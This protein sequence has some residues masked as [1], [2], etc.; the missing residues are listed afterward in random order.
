[1]IEIKKKYQ[2]CGCSACV[3][4]C[5]KQCIS[6]EED[7]EGFLYPIVDKINCIDCGLCEKVCPVLSQEEAR[8][9]L[10]VYATKNNNDYIRRQSSSGGIFTLLAEQIINVG[11]VVFGARFDEN[12]EVKHDFTETIEGLFAFRG[13]KY[14]QSRME[15]NYVKAEAFLKQGRK[16][17]FSGTPCQIVGLKRFLRKEYDNLLTVDFICHGVPSPGIWR[18][19][20]K[21]TIER[22]SS[23]GSRDKICIENISFRD[24]SA[25]WK[26]FSFAL[27]LSATSR[28]GDKK[29]ISLCEQFPQNVYMKGFLA[30]T[31]LRPS[32]YYCPSKSGKSGSDVTLADFWGIQNIYPE[33]DDDKGMNLLILNNEN[34][35]RLFDSV[36]LYKL[37]KINQKVYFESVSCPIK[38]SS[39]FEDECSLYDRV[40]KYCRKPLRVVIKMK[41]RSFLDS[42]GLLNVLRI[43][44]RNLCEK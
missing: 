15:D 20:L 17:L 23:K 13:S 18:Q 24:K 16:V 41:V 36:L 34:H 26:K 40:N 43:I 31:Y 37:D 6:L 38:R 1:M 42:I 11:G 9:P 14:V 7:C 8:E 39:F 2:C 12:W 44:K 21:E 22:M 35:I 25:G 30:N 27:R 4:K 28:S 32:C 5:P 33:L 29:I 19:Y 10:K 3:Q